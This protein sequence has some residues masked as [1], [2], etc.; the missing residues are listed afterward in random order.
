MVHIAKEHKQNYEGK[1]QG[2]S[3][4]DDKKGVVGMKKAFI[5]SAYRG[6]I[7]ANVEKARRYCLTAL[8]HGYAPFAPHLL[9]PQFLTDESGEDRQT[10]M[11]CGIEF[12]KCCDVVFVFGEITEGMQ[13]EIDEAIRLK[14]T[15]SFQEEEHD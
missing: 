15:I 4:D 3:Q 10:G 14:K 13:K 8:D 11:E 6:D 1:H 2:V 9:Y 12:L 7:V 5:C